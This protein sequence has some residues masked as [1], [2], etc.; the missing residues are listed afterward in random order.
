M[1]FTQEDVE[2]TTDEIEQNLRHKSIEYVQNSSFN[3]IADFWTET[4]FSNARKIGLDVQA[5][6]PKYLG[7]DKGVGYDIDR[8]GIEVEVDYIGKH[9]I[10]M[11]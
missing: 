2:S 4:D 10:V 6:M 11:G 3:I 5:V 1:K 7:K 8:W 9:R